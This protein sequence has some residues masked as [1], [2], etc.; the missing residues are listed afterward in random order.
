MKNILITCGLLCF[1]TFS[2]VTTQSSSTTNKDTTSESMAA[3]RKLNGTWEL[4]D[5]PGARVSFAGLYPEKKPVITFDITNNKFTGNTSCN[6]F[7]GLLLVYGSKIDFNK[8]MAMTKMPCQ[9]EGES[10][11]I[12]SLKKVNTYTVNGDNSLTLIEGST[13]VLRLVKSNN[14]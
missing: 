8:S 3:S 5:I 13:P 12:E 11:F 7:S 6:S 14:Q 1:T 4:A 10:A 2:C 9:G